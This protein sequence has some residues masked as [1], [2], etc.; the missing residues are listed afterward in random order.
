[1]TNTG[2]LASGALSPSFTGAGA[3]QFLVTSTDCTTLAGGA[4]CSV[5]AAFQPGATGAAAAALEVTASPGGAASATVNGTGLTPA[6]LALAPAPGSST[7]LGSVATDGFATAV[8]TVT[9]TGGA[10]SGV[11][12]PSLAPATDFTVPS[13]TCTAP[14]PGGGSCS[15]TVRFAPASTGSKAATLTVEATPGGA[16]TASLTGVGITPAALTLAP[17]SFAFSDLTVGS[18]SGAQPFTVTNTG[19]ATATTP[20]ASLTGADANQF[21]LGANTC[22]APLASSGSCS[23]NVRFSP[24]RSGAASASLQVSAA[25]GGTR[26]SG[27]TGNGVAPPVSF[28]NDV[29]PIFA[30]RCAVC[31]TWTWATTVNVPSGCGGFRIVPFDT[32][33]SVLYGKVSGSPPCGSPMPFGGPPLTAAQILTLQAWI[34]QGALNN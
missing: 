34:T 31:H 32:G 8:F 10:A 7:N 9:N 4:S 18:T 30:A 1:V 17:G 12:V 25:T 21:V 28:M 11:P 6:S 3:S 20:I 24:T 14:V 27:L 13:H 5:Q 33:A 22:T 29:A 16:P 15:V 2:D 23:V 19:G 26:T